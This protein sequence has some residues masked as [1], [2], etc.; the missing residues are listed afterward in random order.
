MHTLVYLKKIM[1]A[2]K[3]INSWKVDAISIFFSV[4][5]H[6]AYFYI[7]ILLNLI[8]KII[9]YGDGFLDTTVVGFQMP[10][11]KEQFYY[12]EYFLLYLSS[13]LS[14]CYY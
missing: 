2:G 10:F 13:G 12:L 1:S 14:A 3:P 5:I 7:Y 6:Y 4:D 11:Q 8:L 9:K